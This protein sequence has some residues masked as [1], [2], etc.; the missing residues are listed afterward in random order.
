MWCCVPEQPG[1]LIQ[2]GWLGI[3]VSYKVKHILEHA[4]SKTTG[5]ASHIAIETKYTS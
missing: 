2:P 1:I 3:I 4:P 5:A